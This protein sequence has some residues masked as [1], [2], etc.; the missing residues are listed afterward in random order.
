MY[1]I[2]I[3]ILLC[4][5]ICIYY[6]YTENDGTVLNKYQSSFQLLSVSQMTQ[7]VEVRLVASTSM[8]QS[9]LSENGISRIPQRYNPLVD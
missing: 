8:N 4:I 9:G 6:V 5:Y 7:V 3:Y 2:P 1:I